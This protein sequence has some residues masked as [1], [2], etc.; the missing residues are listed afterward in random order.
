MSVIVKNGNF[1]VKR[2]TIINKSL[3][4]IVQDGLFLYLDAGNVN[5]YPGSGTLWTDL[6]GNGNN[7]NLINGPTF[8]GVNGGTIVFDGTND[9][10]EM[11]NTI[12]LD[13]GIPK[14]FSF[15]VYSLVSSGGRSLISD[16]GYGGDRGWWLFC[17]Y[18]TGQIWFGGSNNLSDGNLIY[19][20]TTN[21]NLS[22][23]TWYNIVLTYNPSTPTASF[24]LNG[25]LLLDNGNTIYNTYSNPSTYTQIG[26][27]G[28]VSPNAPWNGYI[29]QVLG[30]NKVLTGSEILQNY[31]VLKNRFI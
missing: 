25:T 20:T 7:G 23:N 8:S 26:A 27:Y 3:P 16:M 21:A 17:N 18:T 1:T 28:G 14:T 9:N 30:Y 6:T 19:R 29:S 13:T 24:Y 15:W 31:N 22:A 12:L 10:I 11:V 4:N 2:R 5:S